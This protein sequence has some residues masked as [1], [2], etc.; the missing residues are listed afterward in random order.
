MAA[1]ARGRRRYLTFTALSLLVGVSAR[2]LQD[3]VA[4]FIDDLPHIVAA[5]EQ[6]VAPARHSGRT[7]LDRLQRQ[8]NALEHVAAPAAPARAGA[9]RVQIVAPGYSVRRYVVSGFPAFLN[10]AADVWIVAMLTF[11][12]SSTGDLFR[13]KV[14]KLAGPRLERRRVTAETVRAI[15]QQIQRYLA[16]RVLISA[17]VAAATAGGLW[18]VGL[19]HAVVWGLVAGVLNVLPYVGPIGAVALIALAA[20]L[21][22]HG[23]GPTATAAGIASLVAA[24]EGNALTPWLTSRAGELN[25]VAVYIGVLF[26]GWMWGVWGLVLAVPL[27][28]ALKALADRV[29]TFHP[30]GELLGR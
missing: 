10:G 9:V 28:V 21:Q 3:Q 5:V 24:A 20:F 12:L 27:L 22:F 11:L 2:G 13:R 23:F 29:E 26:W 18:L 6:A 30:I 25:A 7:T 17:L 16:V 14:L 4:E 8:T 19:D 15:G 1:A